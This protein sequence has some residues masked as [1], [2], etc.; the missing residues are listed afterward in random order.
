MGNDTSIEWT[1]ATWNPVRGC[2]RVSP[3][4]EHC[5]AEAVAARFSGP[6]LAYEGLAIMGKNGPSWTRKVR[7]VPER[8]AD[9]LRWKRSRRIFAN[10]MSDLFHE[11]LTNEEIAAVFGVMAAAPQHTFQVLTKRAARMRDWF[12]WIEDQKGG[13]AL[14]A[15]W[16]ALDAERRSDIGDKGPIHSKYGPAPNAFWPLPNIHLGVSVEDQARADERIPLLLETPAEVRWVSAEPLLAAIL[17]D[18]K[19]LGQ[20]S[21]C[22]ECRGW[23]VPVDE[24]GCC[25]SCGAYA[26]WYG[27]DWVVVGGESGPGARPFDLAWTRSVVEQCKAAGVACF[28]KQ[29]GARPFDGA[30]GQRCNGEPHEW[31]W[32]KLNDRKGG[33]QSEWPED[34]RVREFPR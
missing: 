29:L 26:M 23:M 30:E 6:G 8:M 24:D 2:S 12:Q 27:L 33:D 21:H 5:Y 28:V 9:P 11:S 22:P 10:S 16:C 18:R 4:C 14:H 25:A 7:L 13:P 17:F 19:H 34:L 20:G 1:D 15:A 32:L 31:A 3:G